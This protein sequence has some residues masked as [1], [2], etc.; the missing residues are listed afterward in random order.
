MSDQR[1]DLSKVLDDARRVITTPLAFYKSMPIGGGYTEPAIF[2]LV[3]GVAVGLVN[4]L[5]MLFSG[6]P[7]GAIATLLIGPFMMVLGSFIGGLIMFVIWKLMGTEQNFETAYRC[8]AYAMGAQP[9]M[10]IL[11]IVPYL[12]PIL[13]TLWGVYLMYIASVEVQKVSANTARIVL[14]ILAL[15][16]IVSGIQ[17]QRT[18]DKFEDWA[19]E[20]E[21]EMQEFESDAEEVGRAMEELGKAVEQSLPDLQKM[22]ELSP[23]EQGRAVGEFFKGLQEGLEKQAEQAESN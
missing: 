15:V 3:M 7:G 22:E 21:Q 17:A 20:T 18:A 4:A 23:E 12:G 8:V 5:G 11:G 2:V 9:V 13:V 14:G 10:A 6:H 1:F 16:M 19:E